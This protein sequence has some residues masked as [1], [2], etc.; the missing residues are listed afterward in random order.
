MGVGSDCTI[1]FEIF[2]IHILI[3]TYQISNLF[4]FYQRYILDGFDFDIET[5]YLFCFINIYFKYNYRYIY[6]I[7]NYCWCDV[8]ELGSWLLVNGNVVVFKLVFLP[9]SEAID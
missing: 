7:N 1:Q 6:I 3:H 2:T 5:K 9:A 8:F 4:F